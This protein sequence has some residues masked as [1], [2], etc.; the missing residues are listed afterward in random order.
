MKGTWKTYLLYILPAEAVMMLVLYR[1]LVPILQRMHVIPGSV[2]ITVQRR[3]YV[4]SAIAGV[5]GVA[6][7]IAYYVYKNR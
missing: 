4:F 1:R 5:I 3:D 2:E 6:V 7:L